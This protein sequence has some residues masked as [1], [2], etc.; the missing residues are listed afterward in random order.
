[1]L[2]E[3]HA[4]CW[5]LQLWGVGLDPKYEQALIKTQV[6]KQAQKTEVARS[7]Q[8]NYKAD[9]Q[10]QISIRDPIYKYM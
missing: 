8:M 6:R 7:T 9:T 1:M 2:K 5:G 3:R 10:V 4:T